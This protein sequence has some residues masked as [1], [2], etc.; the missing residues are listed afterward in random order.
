MCVLTLF[1]AFSTHFHKYLDLSPSLNSRASCTHVD[2]QLGAIDL[3][4]PFS[5]KTSTST[6]GFHLESSI[7]LHIISDILYIYFYFFKNLKVIR[8]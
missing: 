6:V 4:K 8:L 5:I 3:Q 2:A 1:T 7:S